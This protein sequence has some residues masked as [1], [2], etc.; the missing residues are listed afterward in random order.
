ME[1]E[2]ER[3]RERKRIKRKSGGG[4]GREKGELVQYQVIKTTSREIKAE[5]E[6]VQ[7]NKI[8]LLNN[9]EMPR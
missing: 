9:L 5:R 2:A 1:E 8:K 7:C 6:T 4:G 3:E